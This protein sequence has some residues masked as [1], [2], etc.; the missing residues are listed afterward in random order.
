MALSPQ[1]PL[2]EIV[3]RTAKILSIPVPTAAFSSTDPTWLQGVELLTELGEDI[4]QKQEWAWQITSATITITATNYHVEPL[5]SDY[6]GMLEDG[7]IYRSL[8]LEPLIGPIS[9]SEWVQI[10]L[11]GG[12]FIPGAWRLFNNTLNIYGCSVAETLKWEYVSK[13]WM[14]DTTGATKKSAWTA[15]TDRPLIS[16][17]LMRVGLKY[18]WKRA[19]GF[20]YGEEKDAFEELLESQLAADMGL[21]TIHLSRPVRGGNLSDGTWPGTVIP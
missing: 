15:D 4:A 20:D 14:T 7:K 21:R 3:Q 17:Q 8:T 9:S 19:K 5:A 6:S 13:N 2:L 12:S 1:M 11:Y 10:T 18:K 16:D